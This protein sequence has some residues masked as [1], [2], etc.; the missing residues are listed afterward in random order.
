MKILII[1]DE[2]NL[3]DAISSMLKSK[4]Y[5][6]EIIS[7]RKGADTPFYNIDSRIKIIYLGFKKTEPLIFLFPFL[8]LLIK[9][10]L[11]NYNTNTFICVGMYNF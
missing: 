7:V 11:K 2:Y 4:K 5:S 10:K 8:S 1:E 9:K 3:A 6:V